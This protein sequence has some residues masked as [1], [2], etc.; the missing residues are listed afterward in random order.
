MF[1]VYLEY[2]TL[3]EAPYYFHSA[4]HLYNTIFEKKKKNTY[5]FYSSE[6]DK[7]KRFSRLKEEWFLEII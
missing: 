5:N 1:V 3:Y 6:T 7:K 4:T 2:I